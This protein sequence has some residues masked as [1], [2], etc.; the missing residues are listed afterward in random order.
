MS[1]INLQQ[2]LKLQQK[3]SPQQIQVIKMLEYPTVELEER[4]RE[5]LEANPALDEGKAEMPD[6]DDN[7]FDNT[8]DET[9]DNNDFD[10]TEYAA[11]DDIPDYKLQTHNHSAD[12]KETT[13]P[14]S[15]QQSFHEHLT[16]QLGLMR[17]DRRILGLATYIVGNID[18]DGYLRRDLESMAD[19]L[20]FQFGVSASDNDM[21]AALA[22]V[23]NLDPA[24]IA[25]RN[26]QECLLLQ[27]KRRPQNTD[28]A[29]AIT[30]VEKYFDQFSK[31]QYEILAKRLNITDNDMKNVVAEIRRLNPKPG[32]AY[33]TTAEL[34]QAQITPDFIVENDNGRLLVS[35]NN[36]NV[37]DLHVSKEYTDMVNEYVGNKANQTRQMHDAITFAK[38]KIDAA[39]WFIDAL[40]QRNIT[41]LK[42]MNAI[43]E[44]QREYFIDGDETKLRPMKLKDIAEQVGYDISTISRVSNS[45]YVQT[46]FGIFPLKHFFVETM[47]TSDGG[48]T[49]NRAIKTIIANLVAGEDPRNPINDDQLTEYLQKSGYIIARRTVAKYREQLGIQVARLRKEL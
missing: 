22:A 16:D 9:T 33:A 21:R 36:V 30:I 11:D 42:T 28:T 7:E 20:A 49:S 4:I 38:Q 6:N 5:E 45:K 47:Q 27:L 15:A 26:L 48:E 17:L 12:D 32:N 39:R 10:M 2:N 14:L 8:S 13:M 18:D 31:K 23:Q 34:M 44:H 29:R 46:N 3:L 37:P 40:Q 43:V 35:L 1:A 25:A 19:D 41:L 24:G